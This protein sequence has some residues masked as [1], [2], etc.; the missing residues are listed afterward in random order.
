M[1]TLEAAIAL[2]ATAHE[3]QTDK[4]GA[5][6]IFHP[7]R[8]MQA[9]RDLRQQNVRQQNL[10][11]GDLRAAQIAAVLHD[12]VEDTPYTFEDLRERGYSEEVIRALASVTK[13]EGEDDAAF[14]M[15]A[16][17]DPIGRTVKR[18]DLEDNMRATRLPFASRST[19]PRGRRFYRW[20]AINL[21]RLP[22]ATCFVVPALVVPIQWPQ[23]R[24]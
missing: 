13:R 6:Y 11:T 12:L 9:Q 7:L 20:G 17:Q 10:R 2:A 21:G 16:G 5:S 3:G 24:G 19:M 22:C 18:A 15:R 4:A 8:V 14:A 1:P 23:A